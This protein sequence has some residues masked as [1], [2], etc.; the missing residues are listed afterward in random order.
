M[1]MIKTEPLA[2]AILY[3][4]GFYAIHKIAE[5]VLP[6]PQSIREVEDKKEKEK[7]KAEYYSAYPSILFGVT[8]SLWSFHSIMNHGTN[9]GQPTIPAFQR[10]MVF[11]YGYFMHELVLGILNGHLNFSFLFHHVASLVYAAVIAHL[12]YNGSESIK[13]LVMCEVTG[14][15]YNLTT[16]LKAYRKEKL[17]NLVGVLFIVTFLSLRIF[18]LYRMLVGF[19]L[20][21]VKVKYFLIFPTMIW[22]VSMSW[23][24]DM[25]N[26]VS[27]LIGQALPGVGIAQVP[28][29]V[30]KKIRKYKVLYL[31]LVG[32]ISVHH[33]VLKYAEKMGFS[34]DVITGQ[35]K[36]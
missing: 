28:Y 12:G 19:Q 7:E 34:T 8:I 15:L 5:K 35:L 17:R 1:K 33:L 4:G 16:I 36:G 23:V 31:V 27:K 14:P 26:K 6:V 20:K 9:F 11:T 29:K 32:Y 18:P 22:F 21:S 25:L 13:A 2:Q 10:P 30:M 3:A 24:W